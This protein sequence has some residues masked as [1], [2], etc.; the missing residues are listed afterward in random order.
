MIEEI[1]IRE[2]KETD[3]AE[4][5]DL[6]SQLGYTVNP[7][8]ISRQISSILSNKDHFSFVATDDGKV[9]GFIHGFLSIRITSA[10]FLEIAGLIVNEEFR[11]KGVGSKLV[12]HLEAQNVDCDTIRVR[13]N[14]KRKAAHKFY[15]NLGYAEKKEQKVFEK[16]FE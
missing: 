11:N 12:K 7:T 16:N 6:T 8:I 2:I 10:P 13:C 14:V 5:A 4:I 9:I 1:Q 3:A 15:E